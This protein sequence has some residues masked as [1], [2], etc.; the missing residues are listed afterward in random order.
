[1][2]VVATER[3]H[4]QGATSNWTTVGDITSEGTAASQSSECPPHFKACHAMTLS[5]FALSASAGDLCEQQ[6]RIFWEATCFV[7][8][9]QQVRPATVVFVAMFFEVQQLEVLHDAMESG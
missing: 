2:H 8:V 4:A 5:R 1:M 3:C 6:E 9:L 7:P